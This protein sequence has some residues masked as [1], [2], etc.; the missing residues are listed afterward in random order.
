ML[1]LLIKLG[2]PEI[3]DREAGDHALH[4]GLSGGWLLTIWLVFILTKSDH[5]KYK[6]EDWVERHA[7]LLASLT[8][9]KI[10]S[11]EFNDNRVG[12]LLSRPSK[13]EY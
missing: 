13:P 2:V 7:D 10:R 6:V 8:G 11:V 5:T 12:S 3:Y 9:E 4:T 1:S